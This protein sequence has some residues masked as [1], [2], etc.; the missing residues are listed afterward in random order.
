MK[1]NRGR[2]IKAGASNDT[3]SFEVGQPSNRR[4]TLLAAQSTV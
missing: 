2:K 4:P 3:L 1:Q